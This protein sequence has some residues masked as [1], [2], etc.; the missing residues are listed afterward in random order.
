MPE[1]ALRDLEALGDQGRF[2]SAVG[3]DR[4]ALHR[5]ASHRSI[6]GAR[7][8]TDAGFATVVCLGVRMLRERYVTGMKRSE[9]GQ[10]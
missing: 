10:E 7:I 6:R 9:L 3:D 8:Q 5:P 1:A 4:L 2:L